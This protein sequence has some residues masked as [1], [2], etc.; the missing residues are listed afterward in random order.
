[1]AAGG[2]ARRCVASRLRKRGDCDQRSSSS[3]AAVT[4]TSRLASAS[5]TRAAFERLG[6]R[7]VLSHVLAGQASARGVD[8]PREPCRFVCGPVRAGCPAHCWGFAGRGRPRGVGIAPTVGPGSCPLLTS[9]ASGPPPADGACRLRYW[10]S[11][12]RRRPS[13]RAVIR[14]RRMPTGV[15]PA[16]ACC[17]ARRRSASP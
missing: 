9:A 6:L 4:S 16:R 14:S 5:P 2:L 10:R 17:S 7:G 12:A 13:V 11:L 3:L 8:L 15:A 1:M